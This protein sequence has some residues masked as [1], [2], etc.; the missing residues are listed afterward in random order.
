VAENDITAERVRDLFDYD[1]ETGVLRW[2]KGFGGVYSG[3][4]VG[5]PNDRGYLLVRLDKRARKVHRVIWLHVFGEW[6]TDQIDHINGKK[7]DNRLSNLRSVTNAQNHQNKTCAKS[8]SG[9]RGVRER[10]GGRFEASITLN[11]KGYYLGIFTSIGE[12]EEAYKI[13]RQRLHPFSPEAAQNSH[14]EALKLL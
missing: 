4:A 2:K 9:S 3:M 13:A 10:P 6:P 5:T 7:D 14:G 1:P 12:A 11:R 8:K